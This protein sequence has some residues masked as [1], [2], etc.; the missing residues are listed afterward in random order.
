MFPGTPLGRRLGHAG[1]DQIRGISVGT[2]RA[3]K[4]GEVGGGRRLTNAACLVKDAYKLPALARL[5]F[6]LRLIVCR[7]GASAQFLSSNVLAF[8]FSNDSTS[9]FGLFFQNGSLPYSFLLRQPPESTDLATMTVALFDYLGMS[10]LFFLYS[11]WDCFLPALS[12][13]EPRTELVMSGDKKI[14]APKATIYLD[15]QGISALVVRTY[16]N[17]LFRP[18]GLT[19]DDLLHLIAPSCSPSCQ[20]PQQ[21][22]ESLLRIL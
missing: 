3:L 1:S 17:A 4:L 6:R 9:L 7:F 19:L 15:F 10:P 11:A 13:V 2:A 5:R 18:L 16:P 22:Y 8:H 12:S 14:S 21:A 20:G